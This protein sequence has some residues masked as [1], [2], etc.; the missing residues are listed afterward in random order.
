MAKKIDVAGELNPA[1]VE[2]ILADAKVIRDRV[3]NKS[4]EDINREVK[5]STDNNTVDITELKKKDESLTQELE[6][7]KYNSD[8]NSSNIESLRESD[9]ILNERIEEVKELLDAKVIEAGGVAFDTTPTEGSTNPVTSDGIKKA[10]DK[11]ERV[12]DGGRA[13]SKYGGSRVID[14]GRANSIGSI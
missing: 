13:D 5:Q 4:Q 9:Q 10:I 6:D 1:T 2:G 8:G 3:Q 12:Y 7:I 14:C 11:I